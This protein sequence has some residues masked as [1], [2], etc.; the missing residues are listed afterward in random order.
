ML[1]PFYYWDFPLSNHQSFAKVRI[2]NVMNELKSIRNERDNDKTYK[3]L[4][5]NANKKYGNMR[6]SLGFAGS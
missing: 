5:E 1:K 3:K 4:R 2:G 6:S